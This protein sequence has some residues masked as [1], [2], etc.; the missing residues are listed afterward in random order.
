LNNESSLETAIENKKVIFTLNKSNSEDNALIENLRAGQFLK[1]QMAYLNKNDEVGYYSTVGITKYTSKPTLSI[2]G[3]KTE[4]DE[5]YSINHFPTKI[6]GEYQLGE[7]KTERPYSYSFSLYDEQ[8]KLLETSGWILYNNNINNTSDSFNTITTLPYYFKT[9]SEP[10]IN[11][12]I[13][14]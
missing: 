12:K 6:I 13:I 2:Q 14:F 11:Y 5:D 10:N 1:A 9:V 8:D 7:D 3:F 4:E